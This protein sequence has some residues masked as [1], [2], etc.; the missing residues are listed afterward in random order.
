MNP[1]GEHRPS[2]LARRLPLLAAAMVSLL[3]GLWSGLLR[4]GV[5]LPELN[6]DLASLHGLLMV[7]GFLGAQIGLERAVALGRGWTYTVPAAAGAGSLALILGLPAELGQT[8]LAAGGVLLVAVSIAIHRIQPAWHNTVMGLGAAAWA[9]GAIAWLLGAALVDVVPWLA[10]FLILTI[11]GE[12]I[13]LSRMVKPPANAQTAMLAAT[14][15]FIGG[16]TVATWLPDAGIRLAG[17]GLL[18]Q[19]LWLV[20]Y[21]VARRTIRMN[22]A[23]RFMATALLAG[24]FWLAVASVTLIGGGELSGYGFGYDAVL[25]AIFI[26]F[27]FSMIFA[28]APVIVPAVLGVALPYRGSFYVPLVVLHASLAVRLIADALGQTGLWQVAGVLNEVAIVM[29]LALAAASALRAK[30]SRPPAGGGQARA[31]S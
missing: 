9:I 31:A 24:Y 30:R 22:G 1:G 19:T 7:L 8:L 11:V 4:L 26:G 17:A 3:A 5:D 10:A 16:L 12:R 14:A 28:H 2:K 20:R 15:V 21:D 23:P 25:H 27:V 29:Y 18:A 13:E 6:S